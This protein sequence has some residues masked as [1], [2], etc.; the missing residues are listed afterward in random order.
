MA[1]A[2]VALVVVI[3]EI[4]SQEIVA[5]VGMQ[6]NYEF[7]MLRNICYSVYEQKK[8]PNQVSLTLKLLMMQDVIETFP[9]I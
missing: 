9:F 7:E 4:I 3:D 2:L 1:P 8:D 6:V 5:E